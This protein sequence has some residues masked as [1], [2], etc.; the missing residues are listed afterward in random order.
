MGEKRS[1]KKSI[2]LLELE[3]LLELRPRSTAELAERLGI[4][5]RTIQ[6]DLEDLRKLHGT[7][8]VDA[9]GRYYLVTKTQQSPYS[10]LLNY[11]IFR[12]FYHQAPTHHQY[13]LDELHRH[14]KQLP[15]HI[16]GLVARDLEAYRRRNLPSD[17][18]LEMVL[19]AWQERR[20]LQ[21]D[22]RDL[23]GRRFQR[24]LE[25]WF[26]ELNRWNL[27]LYALAR[28]P[29]SRHP[30][31]SVYKLARMSNPVLLDERCSI[32]E[33]FDPNQLLS[34]AWGVTL[35][36]RKVQVVLRFAPEVIPRL[37]EGDLPEAVEWHPLEDG[38]AE[39]VYEVNAGLDGYPFELLGWV[40]SWGSLVEVVAPEDLRVRWLGEIRA[41]AA[42]WG[43]ALRLRE[44]SPLTLSR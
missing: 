39:A 4:S 14:I 44:L 8:Q 5:Q 6:R 32:P 40:L 2:R 27:A 37:R 13:F 1:H 11:T 24:K 43:E 22:Y 20:V 25:V 30:G 33:S 31:P 3:R 10:L 7:V 34:G 17:R 29:G 18:V 42:R 38:R 15:E 28:M 21:V 16:R 9:Q 23:Q 12:F 41:L 36:H 19:R 35:A 26:L